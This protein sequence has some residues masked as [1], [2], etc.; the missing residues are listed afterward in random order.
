MLPA[1]LSEPFDSPEHAYEVAWDGLRCLLYVERAGLLVRDRYGRDVTEKYPEL[2]DVPRMLNGEGHVLD[3]EIV[4]LDGGGRPDFT[5]LEPRLTAGT[6]EAERMAAEAP[7]VFQLFD[8]LYRDGRPVM[9]EPLRTR[10]RMLKQ[11]LRLPGPLVVPDHVV[12]DGIP[13]FEAAR[14]HGLAGIVAKE[15][16]S[17]YVGGLH[18]R[19]WQI[20]RVYPKDQFVIGGYTY[21]GPTRVRAGPYY[22]P[23]FH[24]LLVGQYD[25][26]GQLHCAGEVTGAFSDETM[27]QLAGIFEEITTNRCP[28]HQPPAPER[29]VFWCRPTT[30]VTLAFSARTEEGVLRFPKFE[31]LRLDVPPETCRL[32]EPRV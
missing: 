23:P 3:G 6:L 21:G 10:K 25:R 9:N 24:S 28:F 32:P 19:A 22:S 20:V 16:G 8:V 13:F 26:W 7:I 1:S 29:L 18:S 5:L 17:R 15:L 12:G 11:M 31:S 14:E 30:S 2:R 4:A 27:K